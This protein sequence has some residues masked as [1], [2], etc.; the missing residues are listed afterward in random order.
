MDAQD[1]WLQAH[2]N[3]HVESLKKSYPSVQE[4]ILRDLLGD[5]IIARIDPQHGYTARELR[6]LFREAAKAAGQ[7]VQ[8]TLLN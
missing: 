4:Q 7:K 6:K 2:V 8:S 1:Q 5:E 3:K